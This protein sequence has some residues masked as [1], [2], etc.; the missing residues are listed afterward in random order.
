M[1]AV[2]IIGSVLA[3][4]FMI[5]LVIA[6]FADRRR[7]IRVDSDASRFAGPALHPKLPWG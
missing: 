4:V 1:T 3:G 7:A 5:A 6:A 2:I